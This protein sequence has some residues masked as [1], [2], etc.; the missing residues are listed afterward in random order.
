MSNFT[1]NP[2]FTHFLRNSSE[3]IR[4]LYLT[5]QG[6]FFCRKCLDLAYVTQNRSRLDRIIDKKWELIHKLGGE[7]SFVSD[8][9]KP[10]GMH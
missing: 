2:L 7:S 4:K 1:Q 3:S 6:Y 9:Q 5:R 10:K 8:S